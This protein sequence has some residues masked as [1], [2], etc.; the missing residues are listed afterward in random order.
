[1]NSPIATSPT[2]IG[3]ILAFNANIAIIG[4]DETPA[5]NTFSFNQMVVGSYDPN[6][7]ICLEGDNLPTSA[8][9]EYLHYG[10]AFENTGNYQAENVV[11]KDV[12]DTTKYDVNSIQLINTSHP[13]YTRI[14]GNVVEFIFENI[15]LAA[16]SGNPPVG[17]HGDVLFKIKSLSNLVSGDVA[18][19]S[20][21]IYFDYN[22]PI[23]TNLAETTYSNLNSSVFQLDTNVSVAP[24]P[25]DGMV[26]ITSKF[27]LKSIELFDVQGRILET[28]FESNMTSQIDLSSK[29]NGIY[30]LKINTENGS[31]IEKIVKNK[32]GS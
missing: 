25:T 29:Q 9:G 18:I 13:V 31:K 7:I 12:I 4:S 14:T 5:D 10:I 30:F 24:N 26:N 19:K 11:V 15:N 8:I 2:N 1:V 22:A 32:V 20:A 16:T 17:G 21:H 6:A 27:N 3:D 23:D 28:Q